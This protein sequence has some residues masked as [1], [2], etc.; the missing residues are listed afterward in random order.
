MATLREAGR[1]LFL[2]DI[3]E[4]LARQGLNDQRLIK[5]SIQELLGR[6]EISFR[7]I[8]NYRLPSED[9]RLFQSRLNVVLYLTVLG[10]S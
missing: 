8:K 2:A 7:Q 4:E 3:F 9:A 10:S 5:V 6:G 1:G